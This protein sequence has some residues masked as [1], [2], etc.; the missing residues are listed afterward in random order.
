MTRV[1]PRQ[2]SDREPDPIFQESMA[3]A[4]LLAQSVLAH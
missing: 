2:L 4:R 3:V 1:L